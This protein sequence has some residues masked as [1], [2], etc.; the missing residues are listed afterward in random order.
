MKQLLLLLAALF[1]FEMYAQQT[2]NGVTFPA[3]VKANSKELSL[4]GAGVRKKAIFKVYVLG[5]YTTQKTK[6]AKAVINSNDEV[7]VR[8][9]ITSGVVNSENM[10]EA[11]REG[12]DKSTKG[13]VAPLK[14]KIDAF[15]A[16]FK[17]EIKTGDVF[18]LSYT[19]GVGIKAS[20]NGKL[21]TTVEGE[22]F[23]K[24][25]LGIWLGDDPI[26]TSLKQA[27]MGQ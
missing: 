14:T 21:V 4:N 8:L 12:F 22:D 24:A 20:K 11:I 6:D 13:N 1:T 18:D 16:A 3:K 2:V 23:K 15:I 25:L 27:L 7:L 17:D 5:L 9:Q 19:P 10:S 26:E